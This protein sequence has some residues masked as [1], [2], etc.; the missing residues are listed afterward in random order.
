MPLR[1]PSSRVLFVLPAVLG[2]MLP[3]VA[4]AATGAP[5][6]EGVRNPL[7]GGA[8]AETQVISRATG[9][10]TYG[11]RQSNLSTG[12]DAGGSAIY[13][14]RRPARECIRANNLVGGLAAAFASSG[15][16]LALSANEGTPAGLPALTVSPQLRG[17][18]KNL[19]VE[20]WGGFT[21]ATFLQQLQT[22]GAVTSAP[23]GSAGGDLAGTYPAPELRP[24]AVGTTELADG[25][26]SAPK[27]AT[28]A[29]DGT[30][31]A[32]GAVATA[33]L[34]DGAVVQEKLGG[35]I[36]ADTLG[37]RPGSHYA[38]GGGARTSTDVDI[39]SGGTAIITSPAAPVRGQTHA[40]LAANAT[41]RNTTGS[42]WTV[43]CNL[44][45][46]PSG[47]ILASAPNLLLGPGE[48]EQLA[49]NAIDTAPAARQWEVRCNTSNAGPGIESL[50]Q[51]ITATYLHDAQ[52][53]P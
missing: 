43:N 6:R 48:T 17:E 2:S 4:H 14:C 13:G 33:D 12:A 15:T 37:G 30:A 16:P 52:I 47:E 34:A 27:L 11:T 39:S 1:R 53:V 42:A 50:D 36:D 21:P 20:L 44:R 28:G 7:A 3:A 26:V 49:L 9:S 18:V 38:T 22:T 35:D 8:T 41:V 23:S 40:T 45:R 32:D 10:S 24:A 29:V 31:L 46:S 25:A 19:N 5:L 51:S